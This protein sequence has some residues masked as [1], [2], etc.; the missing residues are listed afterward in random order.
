MGPKRKTGPKRSK[1]TGRRGSKR[2][3]KRASRKP[4]AS[5]YSG[6]VAQSRE[7]SQARKEMA[8]YFGDMAVYYAKLAKLM[9]D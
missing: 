3:P 7:T 5:H 8:Y 2:A 1:S 4:Q 9:S 6:Q